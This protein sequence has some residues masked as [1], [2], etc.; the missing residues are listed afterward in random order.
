MWGSW[1]RYPP[2]A[3]TK[4]RNEGVLMPKQTSVLRGRNVTLRPM[5]EGERNIFYEWATRSS[6]TP[7]W[8]GRLYRG[9]IPSRE[10]FFR[11]WKPH[12]FNGSA[13][14]LGRCFVILVGN[15]AI[16]QVNYNKI[17]AEKRVE[18]DIIIADEQNRGKGYG[19][20]AIKRLVAYLFGRMKV[21]EV[22]V[23]AIKKNPRAIN[24]YKKAGFSA[25]D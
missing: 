14:E 25:T 10:K 1:V 15:K 3:L 13:P 21:R 2:R 23:A 7:F 11:D 22:W 12:Y 9:K 5:N 6:A 20:D 16:G 18:I 4:Q 17:D 8:Y 19:S 24:T